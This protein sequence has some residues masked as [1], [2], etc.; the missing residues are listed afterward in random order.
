MTG[1]IIV[2]KP[3][4]LIYKKKKKKLN[5]VNWQNH[6]FSLFI[7]YSFSLLFKIHFKQDCKVTKKG[8]SYYEFRRNSRSVKS[9]ILHFQVRWM[10]VVVSSVILF[11]DSGCHNTDL[12]HL[13]DPVITVICLNE[14]ISSLWV[15]I[16]CHTFYWSKK[17]N[18]L[19]HIW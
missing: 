17:K 5:R 10:K 15:T 3:S 9:T 4:K 7:L 1:L 6:P 14:L 2:I 13:I 8:G 11:C 12:P 18:S 19:S 16:L